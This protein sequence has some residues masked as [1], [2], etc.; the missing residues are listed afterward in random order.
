[1][2]AL[3]ASRDDPFDR[4]DLEPGHFTASGY[5]LSPDACSVLLIYHR[6]LARWLQ[7]GGHVET[8]DATTVDAARREVHEE[9]GV[10]PE[11]LEWV[12]E[13]LLDVDVHPIPASASVA[14]HEHFDL[15]FLFRAGTRETRHGS[16][17]AATRWT[18][19]ESLAGGALSR[20]ERRVVN[21]LI[22]IQRRTREA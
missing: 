1:M 8:A 7:P 6:R 5:V 13:R 19:L 4:A 2:D 10:H 11:R 17:A 16:D 20:S 22:Q 14:A 15:R 18:P 12:E 9:T 3:L 21:K